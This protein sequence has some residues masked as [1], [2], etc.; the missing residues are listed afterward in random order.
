MHDTSFDDTMLVPRLPPLDPPRRFAATFAPV[1]ARHW[2]WVLGAVALAVA[3]L[4]RPIDE[5]AFDQ[6]RARATEAQALIQQL[7]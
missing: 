7:R 2:P 3:A 6:A 4:S 1:R 5:H